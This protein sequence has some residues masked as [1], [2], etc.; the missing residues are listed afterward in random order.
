MEPAR[1]IR[2]G[3]EDKYRMV[4]VSDAVAEVDRLTHD[5][6]LRTMGRLFADVKTSD[7][8]IGLLPHSSQL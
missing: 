7:E 2:G 4:L 8:I 6:E 5:A 3:V 1:S